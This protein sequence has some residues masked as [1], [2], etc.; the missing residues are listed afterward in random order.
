MR[1]KKQQVQQSIM[2]EWEQRYHQLGEMIP[3]AIALVCEARLCYINRAGVRL[4]GAATPEELIGKPAHFLGFP[5]LDP[6]SDVQ[7]P[8]LTQCFR[9]DGKRVQVELRGGV[10][11]YKGKPAMQWVGREISPMR[12]PETAGQSADGKLDIFFERCPVAAIEWDRELRVCRWSAEAETLLGWRASQ[13]VGK[14]LRDGILVYPTGADSME[15]AIADLRQGRARHTRIEARYLTPSGKSIKCECLLSSVVDP[16][17]ELRSILSFVTPEGDSAHSRQLMQANQSLQTEVEERTAALKECNDRFVVEVVQ[18]TLAKRSLEK[19]L[20]AIESSI[21]GIALLNSDREYIYLNPAYAKLY[22]YDRPSDLLGMSWQNLYHNAQFSAFQDTLLPFISESQ[23][24]RGIAKGIRRDGTEFYQEVSLTALEDDELICIARDISDRHSAQQG[25]QQA[26]DRL[27]AVLDAVPGSVAWISSDLHYMGANKFLAAQ[28]NLTPEDF[29]GQ[30]LGFLKSTPELGEFMQRF[31]ADSDWQASREIESHY[32]GQTRNYLLVAQKYDNGKAAVS[33]GIDITHL[34]E[35]ESKLR[36]SLAQEKQLAQLRSQFISM[37]SHE[38][39][40]PLTTIQSS[41]ELLQHYSDRFS[42]EKKLKHFDRIQMAVK[43]MTDLL[44][45]VL[46][47]GKAETGKLQF[48]PQRLDVKAY[49]EELV[50]ELQQSDRDRHPFYFTFHGTCHSGWM[51]RKLLRH[52]LVNLLSNALKYSPEGKPVRLALNC[53]DRQVTFHI[54]DAGIGIPKD[55]QKRLFETFYRA[56]NATKIEGT[57]LGLAIVKKSVEL[58]GGT[59][60][61]HSEVGE[62]TTFIVTLPLPNEPPIAHPADDEKPI[63]T[64]ANPAYN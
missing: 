47:I 6:T 33:V 11:S 26:K 25:L 14:H 21:D 22:G 49:C 10:C 50:E 51:D 17:G 30:P 57:G 37:T 29:I 15:E 48:Q 60:S 43:R 31:F 5:T 46:I 35:L 23:P 32:Q 12:E 42:A 3:E 54:Q 36:D 27:Q 39:R 58:H 7:N 44:D 63:S 16:G 28:F 53:R 2:G 20:A 59:I 45:D 8:T 62:G 64:S 52:I 38:F 13:V 24:W 18:H 1:Q 34:K 55:D 4:F 9:V 61:V 56:T 40:T 41:T 19:H